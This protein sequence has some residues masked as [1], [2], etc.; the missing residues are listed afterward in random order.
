MA[1]SKGTGNWRS[2]ASRLGSSSPRSEAAVSQ[3][4]YSLLRKQ[5]GGDKPTEETQAAE[6]SAARN[7]TKPQYTEA[8]VNE[9]KAAYAAAGGTQDKRGRPLS[10]PESIWKATAAL[11]GVTTERGERL[12]DLKARVQAEHVSHEALSCRID[13]SL[14]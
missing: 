7:S 8:D 11:L 6:Q 9:A 2:I 4:Y 13:A 5:D 12:E 1:K 14:H 3:H 10:V